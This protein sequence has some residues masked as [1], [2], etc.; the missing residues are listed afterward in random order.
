MEWITVK[1]QL[2]QHDLA[3]ELYVQVP[4]WNQYTY[5]NKQYNTKLLLW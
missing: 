3:C 5:W 2:K 1:E 4:E